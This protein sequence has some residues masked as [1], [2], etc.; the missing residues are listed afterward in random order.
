MTSVV[1][2]CIT[3]T[4]FIVYEVTSF[5]RAITEELL[6]L[7]GV[8]SYNTRAAITFNDQ[9]DVQEILSGLRANSRVLAVKIFNEEGILFGQ[10][11]APNAKNAFL[12]DTANASSGVP[13]K[14]LLSQDNEGRGMVWQS[15]GHTLI[16]RRI[17]LED[18][19]VGTVV[20]EPN[21]A[22]LNERFVYVLAVAALVLIVSLIVAV[23]LSSK[24]QRLVT[25]PILALVQTMRQVSQEKSFTIRAKKMSGDE[26]GLLIDGFNDMLSEI[27]ARDEVL[28]QRQG[29]LQE[30]ANFDNLTHLPNRALYCDRL[31]QS[32]QQADRAREKVV[33]MFI[34]LDHFKDVNDTLGHRVGDMLLVAASERLKVAIRTSDTVARMGGDEFTI[35]L[36]A[37]KNV[38]GPLVVATKLLKRLSEP[39]M[40]EDSEIHVTASIGIA[41]FPDDG[42][43]VEA[44]LKNADTAMYE[45]KKNGKNMFQFY[46]EDMSNRTKSRIDMLGDLHHALERNQLVVYYQPKIAVPGHHV[47]GMEALLR[48]Q[49]HNMGMISPDKFIPLAEETGLITPIGEWVLYEVCRQIKIWEANGHPSYPIAVNVSPIQFKK[50]QFAETVRK[51][52]EETGVTPP[53]IELEVT[54]SAIMQDVETTVLILNALKDMGFK[55][56]V[57]D[58]GTGYSSLSQLKRFPIDTLKIDKSFILN[59]IKNKEDEAIVTAIISMA[60]SLGL[61]IIAEGVETIEQMQMLSD[62]GCYEMQGYL[63]SKPIPPD[64]IEAFILSMKQPNPIYL[65]ALKKVTPLETHNNLYSYKYA[66]P[67]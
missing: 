21:M 5:D 23:F 13:L 47:I 32:M 30:L 16:L 61:N 51:I 25:E 28:R 33:V 41:I 2:L 40:I 24:L 64:R 46:S 63:F 27:E 54:E 66:K 31:Q 26:I 18:N 12:L 67:V 20:I 4:A 57:D 48:W 60:Q 53:L 38:N 19:P 35:L 15:G 9:K 55:I 7:A 56:S 50:P 45:A 22:A 17:M 62:K 10:Y 14:A 11:L 44:L 39:Y 59:I 49:H 52:V 36:P 29:H 8:L 65:R 58:F 42:D 34:D 1:I 6:A 3:A 37:V 43:T